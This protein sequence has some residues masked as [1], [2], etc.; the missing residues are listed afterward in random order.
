MGGKW[1]REWKGELK[2]FDN[3]NLISCYLAFHTLLIHRQTELF[4]NQ[5]SIEGEL[6][7]SDQLYYAVAVV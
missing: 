3:F 2:G 1:E 7:Q 4:P 6:N 5:K